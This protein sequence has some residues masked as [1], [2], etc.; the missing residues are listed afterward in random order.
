MADLLEGPLGAFAATF[1]I[2][3][4]S[5]CGGA[6]YPP[7]AELEAAAKACRGAIDAAADAPPAECPA[8]ECRALAEG[9]GRQCWAG[10]HSA[11]NALRAALATALE[12]G[13]ALPSVEVARMQN[14]SDFLAA[15]DPAA[16]PRTDLAAA[17]EASNATAAAALRKKVE[18]AVALEAACRPDSP[19][20]PAAPDAEAYVDAIAAI[21]K[22]DLPSCKDFLFPALAELKAAMRSCAGGAGGAWVGGTECPAQGGT[23]GVCAA[24]APLW[25]ADC[26]AE[27]TENLGGVLAALSA[28]LTDGPA[29]S[30]ADVAKKQAWRDYLA[31][32]SPAYFPR[33][34][35]AA[36]LEGGDIAW[37]DAVE[38]ASKTYTELATACAAAA[39]AGPA[40]APA[41]AAAGGPAA[42][43]AEA[44]SGARA[45]AAAAAAVL[46]AALAI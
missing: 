9:I 18:Y 15:E 42:A 1:D 36:I 35:L 39:G 19:P 24:S 16:N 44:A 17:L 6:L 8:D 4:A 2:G 12:G 10:F 26:L 3:L 20:P 21:Y 38:N 34:D 29:M 41:S 13:K 28:A 40:P 43:A 45:P 22:D 25:G 11:S 32:T 33:V 5:S 7:S 46:L 31:R 14:V 37:A 27:F 30:A 23:R